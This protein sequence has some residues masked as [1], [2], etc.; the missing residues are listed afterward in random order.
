MK[1]RPGK[2]WWR[3][4]GW[5]REKRG[6]SVGNGGKDNIY[7]AVVWREMVLEMSPLLILENSLVN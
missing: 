3:L 5:D 7:R 1:K 2:G 4:D 6:Q